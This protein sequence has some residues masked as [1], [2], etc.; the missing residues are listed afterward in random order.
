MPSQL[1]TLA[2]VSAA[3][4]QVVYAGATLFHS[5]IAAEGVTTVINGDTLIPIGGF[6][7]LAGAIFWTGFQFRGLKDDV[8]QAKKSAEKVEQKL[9]SLEKDVNT[10]KY[11]GCNQLADHKQVL[12]K[13]DRGGK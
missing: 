11:G 5:V 2:T 3:G 4:S 6:A 1:L 7:I 9:E 10:L 13:I 8:R 12:D